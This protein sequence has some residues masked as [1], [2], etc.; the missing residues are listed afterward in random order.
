M[1]NSAVH[2]SIRWGRYGMAVAMTILL[3]TATSYASF[4]TQC[5]YAAFW[6]HPPEPE[7]RVYLGK[8]EYARWL[9]RWRRLHPIPLPQPRP[10]DE[11]ILCHG[12]RIEC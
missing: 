4:K 11:V 12:D 10:D 8:R 3:S 7:C 5:E 6:N 9:A 1:A 2:S